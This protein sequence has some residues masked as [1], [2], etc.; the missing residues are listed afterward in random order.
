MRPQ[1][2]SPQLA[3][4]HHSFHQSV[5][6]AAILK[7]AIQSIEFVLAHRAVLHP[8]YFSKY[9]LTHLPINSIPIPSPPI[10]KRNNLE[11]LLANQPLMCL[12]CGRKLE[13][14]GGKH[15]RSQRK[16]ANSIA[17]CRRTWLSQGRWSCESSSTSCMCVP[18]CRKSCAP[19]ATIIPISKYFSHTATSK[20]CTHSIEAHSD[21]T[22]SLHQPYLLMT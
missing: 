13:R 1:Q 20:L 7:E 17:K 6:V 9:I 5:T 21:S 10:R 22:Q 11:Q 18:L 19:P 3:H 15:T 4:W 14:P 12:R 16:W 8:I 2:I